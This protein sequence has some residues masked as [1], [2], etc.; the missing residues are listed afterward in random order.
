MKD[1]KP[2]QLPGRSIP[3]DPEAERAVVGAL[4][5]DPDALYKIQD[6]IRPEHF[7]DKRLRIVYE[8]CE[9]L[10]ARGLG[11]TLITLRH[12]LEEHG[13]LEAIGGAGFL[14]ELAESVPTAAH[15]VHN[16]SVV[17]DKA[18]ARSLIRTCESIAARGYDAATPVGDLLEEAEREVMKIATG[19]ARAAFVSI[20]D[21][22]KPT[23]EHINQLQEG[24]VTGVR[25]SFDDF[26][27]L[28]GGLS[29]GDLVILAARPSVGKTALALNIARNCAVLGGGCVGVFSLEMTSRQLTLRML[30]ADAEVDLQ[31]IRE[32]YLGERDWRKLTGAA[33]VLQE[34]RIF[35]DDLG[36]STVIDI[37]ARARRLH[38]EH[39]VSLLVVDYIQLIQGGRGGTRREQE[40]AETTR[41]LKL[42]A[43]D[44]DIPIL[45]LSQLNRGPELRP[46]KRPLLADLRESGAI[47]QDADIVCFIYR[48]EMYDPE[49]PDRGIAELIVAKQ[50]NGPT[51]VVR[52][53]FDSQFTRFSNLAGR[54]PGPPEQGF[55]RPQGEGALGFETGGLES[56]FE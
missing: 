29:G 27:K 14:A 31:R 39:G 26:D 12:R 33:S 37:S 54:E 42:L 10:L 9:S 18:L 47:E 5:L 40:V 11:L 38:R 20:Q 45:A 1:R 7:D 2:E 35:I 30:A 4:L 52:L 25:T 41:A 46:N 44:L 15:I 56:P 36:V 22:L 3:S 34:A 19:Q 8:A 55:D 6:Q 50:R 43:K 48:D 28:S 49:S 23:F 53:Q 21:E 24:L 16:A 32:G 13:Q 17:R 51:G